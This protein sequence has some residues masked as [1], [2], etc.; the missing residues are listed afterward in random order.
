MGD[1]LN[2][3]ELVTRGF[4]KPIPFDEGG[5][6]RAPAETGVY[7]ITLQTREIEYLI[8]SSDIVIIGKSEIK[9][10]IRKRWR[11]YHNPGPSQ[12]TNLR[13]KPMFDSEPHGIAWLLL[14]KG[15]ASVT[16]KRLLSE[17]LRLHGGFPIYNKIHG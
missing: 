9:Q 16:E 5:Q 7:I 1:E 4:T 14:Q 12:G 3:E 15:Q 10:G 11:E 6:S 8:G 2:S 17:F 13:L